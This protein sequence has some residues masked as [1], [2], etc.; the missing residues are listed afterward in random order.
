[1]LA[2]N[3]FAPR[4]D[5]FKLPSARN[6]RLLDQLERRFAAPQ[7]TRGRMALALTVAVVADGLQLLLGPLGWFAADEVIDVVAMVLT[8]WLL[9]FHVL[10]LPTFVVEFI[11]VVDMLPSWTA[12]VVAVIALRK[13]DA[14]AP[15]P[16][17]PPF[18]DVS[19]PPPP[20]QIAAASSPQGTKPR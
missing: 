13:R 9:G 20:A 4:R 18:V 5:W 14:A 2:R 7:L 3:F 12:C 15:P 10:L 8:T 11:P 6:M 16:I 19:P 1:M 17:A